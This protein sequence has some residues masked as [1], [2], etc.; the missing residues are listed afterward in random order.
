[1]YC[2]HCGAKLRDDEAF[3]D[4]CG[5]QVKN[6]GEWIHSAASGDPV[7]EI[8]L[9]Q[10]EKIKPIAVVMSVIF[11][12]IVALI[13]FPLVGGVIPNMRSGNVTT[14]SAST[15]DTEPADEVTA[16]ADAG[17]ETDSTETADEDYSKEESED[18]Y[19]SEVESGNGNEDKSDDEYENE[20]AD[21][22]TNENETD[23]EETSSSEAASEETTYPSFW[24]QYPTK[25][26]LIFDDISSRYLTEDDVS[27]LNAD[28]AQDAINDIYALHGGIF[29]KY[30]EIN[31]YYN[32]F[33]WYNGT[34]EVTN[35]STEEFNDYERANI[36][37]LRKKITS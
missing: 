21:D 2:K 11:I 17:D 22:S 14:I 25:N 16:T 27:G 28:T 15:N 24:G 6:N 18:E 3:C 20:Y 7:T 1:M 10:G 31:D 26:G 4:A 30:P 12:F 23:T 33:D 37:L 5:T 9:E 13:V 19:E 32:Q 8:S 36:D 29:V 34:T 35:M